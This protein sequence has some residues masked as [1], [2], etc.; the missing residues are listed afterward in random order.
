MTAEAFSV[1][2]E[3]VEAGLLASI[4]NNLEYFLS[5]EAAGITEEDF[6]SHR[7]VW[8]FIKQHLTQYGTLPSSSQLSTRYNWNPPLGEFRYWLDEMKRYVLA[9]KTM[10]AMQTAFKDLQNGQPPYQTVSDLM[11]NLSILRSKQ[12]S[13]VDTFEHGIRSRIEKYQLRQQYL[14]GGEKPAGVRTNLHI[15]DKTMQG[16][17]PSELIGVYA[18]PGVGKTWLL[19]WLAAIAWCSGAKVLFISPEISS[20]MLGLRSD[21]LVGDMLGYPLEYSKIVKG[22]PSQEANYLAMAEA[23]DASERWWTYDSLDGARIGLG[24]IAALIQRHKPDILF[25]DGI[26]LLNPPRGVNAVWEQ[27]KE[28]CYS[29]KNLA[30]INNIPIIM[31]HQATNSNRGKRTEQATGSIGRG[32]DFIMPSLNDA[33]YGDAFV[34]AC[35]TIITMVADQSSQYVRWFSVRKARDRGWEEDL[36]NRMALAWDVERGKIVDLSRLGES[37]DLVTEEMRKVLGRNKI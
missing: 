10:N 35:N 27:M 20:N 5:I 23:I 31:S 13:H 15:I 18:R 4:G 8:V 3:T 32:D 29:M 34:Q 1:P 12:D 33:A 22:D 6:T 19:Q 24:D 28:M 2:T 21:V 25:V 11:A 14:F 17:M 30:T 9:A 36:P 26:S 37:I 7:Q 16:W